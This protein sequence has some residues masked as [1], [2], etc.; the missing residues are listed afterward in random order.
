MKVKNSILKFNEVILKNSRGHSTFVHRLVLVM[1]LY[2]NLAVGQ[3]VH[4]DLSMSVIAAP[5]L[6]VDSNVESPSTYAPEAVHFAVKI[7]NNGFDD[8][9]NVYVN[10]GDYSASPATPGVYR[11]RTV[12]ET[13]Y[14]GTFSFTHSGSASD[15]TRYIKTLA[16]GACTV[17]Y[18]LVEYPRLDLTGAKVTGGANTDDDLYLEYDIWAIANDNGTPLSVDE[19]NRAYMRSEISAM[20]NKIWP[21]GTNKVPQEY[22]DAVSAFL[23][24]DPQQGSGIGT[25]TRLDGIWF[26]LGRVNKG[27]DSNGDFV[28]DYNVF[29]QP[30]GDPNIFDTDCFRLVKTYGLVIVKKI[31]GTEKLIPFEDQMYFE[32]L[33][34]NNN[35]AVGLVY[36]EFIALNGPCRSELTPYQEVAS[37][38]D[39]EKFNGDYGTYI[40][41]LISAAPNATLDD[42][43]VTSSPKNASV[44]F[45]IT[46]TN[47]SGADLGIME[48][49]LPVVMAT[50]IPA[51]TEYV[52]GSAAL[53]NTLPAGIT[54][55]I[56]YST[57][58]GIT[59]TITEPSTASTVT[60]IQW[61]MSDV[62]PNTEV[63]EVTFLTHIPSGY[64]DP[65]LTNNGS[66]ALGGGSPFLEDDH[67][68]LVAGPNSISGTVFEDDGAGGNSGNQIHNSGDAEETGLNTIGV[69]LYLDRDEDGVG[70]I[71]VASTTTDVN[72][73]Y[74]FGN[75]PDGLYEVVVN[76]NLSSTTCDGGA[77]TG[78]VLDTKNNLLIELDIAS[79]IGTAVTTT[80]TDFG[81]IPALTISKT[82]NNGASVY[83]DQLISYNI[84][85]TNNSYN[86]NLDV[87][88]AWGA[89]NNGTSDFDNFANALSANSPDG[90]YASKAFTTSGNFNVDAT[91]FDF[92]AYTC[93]ITSVEAVFHIY[94]SATLSN[95]RAIV[96]I[97]AGGITYPY[98]IT[99]ATLNNFVGAGNVGELKVNIT[100]ARSWTWAD[101]QTGFSV[102]FITDKVNAGDASTLYLDGIGIHVNDGNTSEC[103][104]VSGYDDNTLIN[105]IP[106]V[107]T[108]DAT[109]LQYVS[110]SI[111]PDVVASG[112]LT[113][114]NVM[115]LTPG[116]TGVVTVYFIPLAPT[117][118]TVNTVTATGATFLDGTAVNNRTATA[119]I[120]ILNTGS[121][122]GTTWSEGSGG[123]TGWVA[124]QGYQGVDLFLSGVTMNLYGCINNTTG[125]I[126]NRNTI[127]NTTK[128]CT[129]NGGT[130]TQLESIQT[131]INGNYSFDGLI[132]GYYYAAVDNTTIPG[133]ITQTGDPDQTT[134]VCTTCNAMWKN[135]ASNVN[136]VGEINNGT[137]YT[138]INFGYSTNP[139]IQGT[140]WEDSYTDGVNNSGEPAINGVTVE[141]RHAGCTAGVNCPTTTTNASGNYVFSNLVAGTAYTIAVITA[142]LPAGGSWTETGES[143]GSINNSISKTL[144]A[145]QA[146]VSNNFGFNQTGSSTIGDAVY[147][148]WDGDGVPDAGETNLT[149][150]TVNLYEDTNNDGAITL[151]TDAFVATTITTGTGY[152]FSNI[153]AGN[154]LVAIDETTL[155]SFTNLT[156]DPDEPGVTCSICDAT[157][158]V[159]TNG[160]SNY[161]TIDFGYQPTGGT[162]I[163]GT[164]WQ[165]SNGDAI[166]LAES[167]IASVTVALWA[168]TD[169][170]GIYELAMTTTSDANGNYTFSN[171]PDGN[172]QI[173]VSTT[174]TDI[175]I[176]AFGN[177]SISTNGSTYN[178]IIFEGDVTSI[179]S[180]VCTNCSNDFDFG[181]AKLGAIGSTVFSDANGNG[182]Q[183]WTETG[184]E[185]VTVYLCDAA[186][187]SC[188]S[189]SALQTAVTDNSGNYLFSGLLPGDYTVTVNAGSLGAQTADPNRDGETCLS[190]L[191][192]GLPA[193]DNQ[194]EDIALNYG[195]NFMGANFGYQPSGIIGDYI[196]L[197]A[198]ANGIQDAGEPG[199]RAVQ[200]V[201]T[202]VTAVTIDGVPYAAG[203]YVSTVYTDLDGYYT[204]SD[205]PDGT[206][207]IAATTPL[208][209]SI[210]YD[211]D[212]VA[213]GTTQV[214]ISGG[215]TTI[216]GNTC[217]ACSLDAD[218]GYKLNGAFSLSGSVCMDDGSNDGV[219]STGGETML[220]GTIVYL[221]NT[222]GEFLG[223]TTVAVSGN[224][225]FENLPAGNYIVAIGTTQTPLNIATTTTSGVTTTSASVYKSI[226]LTANTTGFDFGFEYEVLIDFGDLPISYE[227]TKLSEGGAYHIIE[228]VPTLY[229]GA[230][231]DDETSPIQNATATGDA[232]D[233]GIVFID[234]GTWTTGV[235]GGSLDATITGTG[236]LVAWIDFNQD[237]D[238]SDAG[239][240]IISQAVSASTGLINFDIPLGTNLAGTTF[241]RFRLFEEEPSFARFSY[242]GEAANGEVEDYRITFPSLPVEL[243]EFHGKATGCNNTLTWR[244]ESEEG[245]SHY[246]L[247]RSE[248]GI[249]FKKIAL[250]RGTGDVAMYQ[251]YQYFDE[252]AKVN[253][254]YRL[255]MVDLDGSFAY[256][257]KVY[258][259]SGC[260]EAYEMILYPNP[261]SV[262]QGVLNIKFHSAAQS[263][264][265]LTITDVLGQVIRRLTLSAEASWNTLS[266]DVSD[267]AIGTYFV[268]KEGDNE[269]FRFVVQE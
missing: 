137:D 119:T 64:L 180:I 68:V 7:C 181:F 144:V 261:I 133:T 189:G 50:D 175:P 95:D 233:D 5:N 251:T 268:K 125:V 145:G 142:S 93:A 9:S 265:I 247:E 99:T 16:A 62:I 157:G 57:D 88:T 80:D 165:D 173:K 239:E 132:D 154:F 238:I 117:A 155:P 59:W 78:W 186:S 236:W 22:L 141:L 160:T 74:T 229:L 107:D 26:D 172:Y 46:L 203:T 28:P 191:Y 204:Y 192:P 136:V 41:S 24:W 134:G 87:I 243:S 36:Y 102:K 96:E 226:A 184:I 200:V 161:T 110:A 168:D 8:M 83:E 1:L 66:A 147:M 86:T 109:K 79:V 210:T 106:L 92:D 183:D 221:Y 98:T 151:G 223:Q 163:S 260:E 209:R 33:P 264:V 115:S 45:N 201:L 139:S 61:W 116:E 167:I 82:S 81:F 228:G 27:F 257:K 259:K 198:N 159:T 89:T 135:P 138:N 196:W 190:T 143:D 269:V 101:F 42:T 193:C 112:S 13:T 222:S 32:N 207:T 219:C 17:Q 158:A 197:D 21:N 35:G 185:G 255:K 178:M 53:N 208:N 71:L 248:D 213:N 217:T 73:N 29:M 188:N 164:V 140:I 263:D 20:A 75:L 252:S 148:D 48:Y 108:Y 241:S 30:V 31:D 146:S 235:N 105:R 129:F 242:T 266:L 58:G 182:S 43:G 179:N 194:M 40:P 170:N 122:S 232:T 51:G 224:Y 10:I 169:G 177:P 166:L 171:L 199:I 230:A 90:L 114:N 6:I 52:A 55:T 120:A 256:S 14:S 244:S 149:G 123:T 246:V 156:A 153:P 152:I 126:F 97:T 211:A 220:G 11:P 237:G 111:E 253:N 91:G 118:S 262:K 174:D 94:L 12:S 25:V 72:G 49:G 103:I 267:L 113:W 15:A 216:A 227:L 63:V 249:N 258:I 128:T 100:S 202:N 206:Y 195:T 162:R 54:A 131:D 77:C 85:L 150:I 34:Q 187:P 124:T 76:T 44:E 130:W 254:Y 38:S 19:T 23:G 205:L 214:V 225:T 67:T 18:W 39:N 65:T 240:M 84:S 234:Q 212:G 215:T 4:G 2:C 69:S 245:F 56:L 70:D 47:N 60:N 37:G 176:D 218:F 3:T 104:T 250:V 231:V 127:G 121:I